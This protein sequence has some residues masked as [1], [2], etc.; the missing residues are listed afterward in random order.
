MFGVDRDQMVLPAKPSNVMEL[1]DLWPPPP[2][3][4]AVIISV[5]IDTEIESRVSARLCAF[6][7]LVLRGDP[8]N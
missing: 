1:L 2:S 8:E 3:S 6:L 5:S 7:I 4:K